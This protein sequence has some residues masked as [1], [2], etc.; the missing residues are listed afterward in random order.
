MAAARSSPIRP[1]STVSGE[2][3]FHFSE[4]ATAPERL[5]LLR[6]D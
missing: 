6:P 4:L 3:M 1:A 2:G 5:R